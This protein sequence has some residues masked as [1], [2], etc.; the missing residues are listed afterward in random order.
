[1]PIDFGKLGYAYT[2]DLCTAIER[3]TA[4]ELKR[5]PGAFR[6]RGMNLQYA[7]ERQ[8]YIR[9]IN[10]SMLFAYY[11]KLQ[12]EGVVGKEP[13]LDAIEADVAREFSGAAEI[14][15]TVRFNMRSLPGYFLLRW[16]YRQIRAIWQK[17]PRPKN[18]AEIA[19]PPVLFHIVHAKFA[20]YLK[21]VVRYLSSDQYAYLIS[22]DPGLAPALESL[23]EPYVTEYYRSDTIHAVFVAKALKQFEGLVN[24][25]DRIHSAISRIRPNCVVLVEGNAP[26]DIITAEVCAQLQIPTFCIQQGWSPVVH[27]GFRNMSFDEMFV[28]GEGFA[29][30]LAPSNP[31]QQFT[32]TGNHAIQ[33]LGHEPTG[34]ESRSMTISFFLQA[35]CAL[36]S[37]RGYD[38]FIELIIWCARTY[39]TARFVV[40]EHPSYPVPEELLAKMKAYNNIKFSSP[41]RDRLADV[42]RE[43]SLVVS[44]FSTVLLEAVALGTVPLICGIGSTPRYEPDLA[45]AGAAIEVHSVA[46]A[47]QVINQ[48]VCEPGYLDRYKIRLATVSAQYFSKGE[49]ARAISDKIKAAAARSCTLTN[50]M[51]ESQRS[52]QKAATHVS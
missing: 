15:R 46:A 52:K 6:Y 14:K 33:A 23:N 47:M 9:C 1:M 7:V 20:S 28:W 8:L 42:I 26:L 13:P 50:D 44:V 39:P 38:E 37:S 21:P 29:N 16:L 36:L 49:A 19:H 17:N 25:A 30:L 43:S 45:G 10:S 35:P 18:E 48:V 34:M 4:R 12:K 32:V 2:V 40:R 24:A 51:T 3:Y 27:S 11:A 5:S 22:V 41:L 31:R